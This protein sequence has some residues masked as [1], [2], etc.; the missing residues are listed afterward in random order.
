MIKRSKKSIKKSKL[1]IKRSKLLIY[2]KKSIY[3]DFFGPFQFISISYQLKS[4]DFDLYD[5]IQTH[6]DQFCHD[7]LKSGFKFGWKMLIK[8][9]FDHNI[10]GFGDL[11]RLHRLSLF[12]TLV[13][14]NFF[15]F[16]LSLMRKNKNSS[17]A[18]K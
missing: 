12:K 8:R 1:L 16:S 9:Q 15:L 7:E 14:K 13:V 17:P 6:F 2:I 11:D 18:A 5:I 10:S 4:I 3:F